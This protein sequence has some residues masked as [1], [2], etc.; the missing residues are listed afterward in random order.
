LFQVEN[1]K[2]EGHEKCPGKIKEMKM[3]S[4]RVLCKTQPIS[5]SNN[6]LINHTPEYHTSEVKIGTMI[7]LFWFIVLVHTISLCCIPSLAYIP[8]FYRSSPARSINRIAT[9]TSTISA[10]FL[11]DLQ[12]SR[13]TAVTAPC[14]EETDK[15]SRIWTRSQLDVFAAQEEVV[16][17]VSTIGPIFRAVARAQHNTSL[18]L[19]YVEGGI[20]PP[21]L[22]NPT[23]Q[24]L[25]FDSMRVFSKMIQ[26]TRQENSSFRNGGTI[27]GVG[28]L[29]GYLCCLHFIDTTGKSS[30][31]EMTAE[32]LAIDDEARQHERL[33]KYYR[34]SGFQVIKY[35]GDDW[36]D[37][38]DRLVWG[39]C[40]TLL[41]QNVRTLL[42]KWTFLM[43]R[44]QS[45]KHRASLS[46]D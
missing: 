25:H 30:L 1:G 29:L 32:F 26:Q 9:R 22:L 15:N 23:A 4:S 16:L 12:K 39:G 41:R 13:T 14:E 35:V 3:T 46:S 2:R 18:V 40:G 8:T 6:T 17:S 21:S 34:T 11:I 33:V 28:L 10:Q 19:G 31:E 38:P 7:L 24:I 44:S 43:Q 5:L 37:I 27:L 42:E 36:K 20:R 45:R